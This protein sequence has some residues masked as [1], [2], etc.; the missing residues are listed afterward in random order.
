MDS[1]QRVWFLPLKPSSRMA[2]PQGAGALGDSPATKLTMELLQSLLP[3]KSA[4]NSDSTKTFIPFIDEVPERTTDLCWY[5][6]GKMG[7]GLTNVP[8][9]T[10]LTAGNAGSIVGY[11]WRLKTSR[12]FLLEDSGVTWSTNLHGLAQAVPTHL[13][14]AAPARAHPTSCFVPNYDF[15]EET[16]YPSIARM[17]DCL[18]IHHQGRL[19]VYRDGKPLGVQARLTLLNCPPVLTLQGPMNTPLGPAMAIISG[20]T[21]RVSTLGNRFIVFWGVPTTNG[22][23]LVRGPEQDCRTF[24][25][26]LMNAIKG[27]L[28]FPRSISPPYFWVVSAP[29]QCQNQEGI[30]LGITGQGELLTRSSIVPATGWSLGSGDIRRDLL[31]SYTRN[32]QIIDESLD[33]KLICRTPEGVLWLE[34]SPD[35]GFVVTREIA[36]H[37]G[38]FV[39]SFV[40]ETT[41]QLFLTVIDARQNAYLAVLQK[42]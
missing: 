3:K 13:F 41:H 29:D 6:A 19:E 2:W 17:G 39:L 11:S 15:S 36:L 14:R 18:W 23:D 26:P 24:S 9:E 21:D 4:T 34:R 27:A 5:E 22:I 12:A 25:V 10:V 16:H 42:H 31:V 35:G 8:F 38:G 40:G 30:P 1:R 28:Y 37:T 32:L 7:L 33:G 20:R